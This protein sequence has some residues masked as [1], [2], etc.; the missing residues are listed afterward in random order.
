MRVLHTKWGNA[1]LNNWGYYRISSTEKG[2]EGKLLHRLIYEDFW[3]VELPPEIHIHHKDENKLNN[4]ILNLEAV[5]GKEHS[6]F[7]NKGEKNSM[8]GKSKELSPVFGKT[9]S[10][11]V[12]KN[13]SK[14]K[15]TTGYF[16]V[17]KKKEP[18]VKQGFTWKYGFYKNRKCYQTTSVDLN[19]LKEKVLANGW[20]WIKLDEVCDEVTD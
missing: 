10:L 9:H 3:G 19:K 18:S 20:E 5:I 15:N 4:C 14:P 7:H 8:Y 2:Y 16:R 12:R 1:T 17:Y 6:S 11:S 13:M